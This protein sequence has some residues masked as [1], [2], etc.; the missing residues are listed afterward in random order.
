MKTL[1]I[2][3][4]IAA[5]IIAAGYIAL[6]RYT[7]TKGEKQKRKNQEAINRANRIIN[8]KQSRNP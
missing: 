5:I 8:E 2:T 3:L 7:K 4:L 1:I 6:K